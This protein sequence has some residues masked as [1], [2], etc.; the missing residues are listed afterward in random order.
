MTSNEPNIPEQLNQSS[1]FFF[2]GGGGEGRNTKKKGGG[3][4]VGHAATHQNKRVT[5]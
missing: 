2:L 3:G 5:N 1:F 4:G